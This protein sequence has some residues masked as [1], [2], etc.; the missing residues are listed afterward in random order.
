MGVL[1]FPDR[2]RE[3]LGATRAFGSAKRRKCV[4]DAEISLTLRT[5]LVQTNG[6]PDRSAGK[7]CRDGAF[8]ARMCYPASVVGLNAG[9]RAS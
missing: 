6:F 9:R 5:F 3:T 4:V 2:T 7:P 8:P 1:V